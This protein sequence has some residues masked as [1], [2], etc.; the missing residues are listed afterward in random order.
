L[1]AETAVA[2][3][4][5]DLELAARLRDD[6]APYAGHMLGGDTALLGTGDYLIG[7]IA[8]VEGRYDDAIA[9]TTRAIEIADRWEF[10]RLTAHHRIDLARSLLARGGAGDEDLA[11]ASLAHAVETAD[12]L[13][14]AAAAAEAHT[15]LR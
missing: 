13:G 14:L 7:R 3:R 6:V 15:L 12:R 8:F 1:D 5:G 11:R 10:D 9:A 2:Y 4:V